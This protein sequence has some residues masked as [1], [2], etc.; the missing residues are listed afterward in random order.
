MTNNN[1]K[2][3]IEEKPFYHDQCYAISKAV[4]YAGKHIRKGMDED[5]AIYLG[6]RKYRV[7]I[8]DVKLYFGDKQL[9]EAVKYARMLFNKGYMPENAIDQAL[10]FH[11]VDIVELKY[12]LLEGPLRFEEG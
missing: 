6:A 10:I 3:E 12:H 2:T 5:R 1:N 7:S 9:L 8:R 4:P 11:K